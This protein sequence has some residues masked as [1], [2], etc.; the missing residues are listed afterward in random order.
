MS[1]GLPLIKNEL[2]SSAKTVLLSLRLIAAASAT[3]AAIQKE[4]FGS[5]ITALIISY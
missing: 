5:S 3:G 2:I 4:I 1:A